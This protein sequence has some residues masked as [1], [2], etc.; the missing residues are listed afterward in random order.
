[1]IVPEARGANMTAVNRRRALQIGISIICLLLALLLLPRGIWRGSSDNKG[2]GSSDSTDGGEVADAA[3]SVRTKSGERSTPQPRATHL[4]EALPGFY[5]PS[6]EIEGLTLN[7]ALNLILLKYNETCE[8]I[9]EVPLRIRFLTPPDG[10][11]RI[12]LHLQA[13]S[14]EQAVRLLAAVSGL[15]VNRTGVT[16]KF[17]ESNGN[18][19]GSDDITVRISPFAAADLAGVLET[20]EG[21]LQEIFS[22]SGLLT[23][24]NTSIS[25]GENGV[26]TITGGTAGDRAL[27]SSLLTTLGERTRVQHK[28][29]TKIVEL[30]DGLDLDVPNGSVLSDSEM[31]ILM[32]K[33]A[34]AKGT[35]LMTMPSITMRPDLP[36]EIKIVREVIVP[37][38]GV[39]DPGSK[40]DFTKFE[41]GKT[42]STSTSPLGLGQE[43][44]F[45]YEDSE[46][47]DTQGETLS[48]RQILSSEA[49]GYQSNNG[50]RITISKRDDGGYSATFVTAT[51]IDATGRPVSQDGFRD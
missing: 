37:K 23:D 17:L 35:E 18:G 5:L 25:T 7:E 3:D 48:K 22:S 51:L 39:Q 8:R 12:S 44:K 34:M 43:L 49:S 38:A 31:Q 36:G 28:V 27:I 46:I 16:Y 11:K 33:L 19:S 41:V 24:P 13:T 29:M 26:V 47:D 10:G 21:T 9:G 14:F 30:P 32:R 50:T 40:D 42:M 15:E 2:I 45:H 6:L 1:M 20:N 4:P